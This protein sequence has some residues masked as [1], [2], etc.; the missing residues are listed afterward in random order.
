MHDLLVIGQPGRLRLL[1]TPFLIFYSC[2]FTTLNAK[3]ELCLSVQGLL[4]FTFAGSTI[5]FE[6]SDI[7]PPPSPTA[8]DSQGLLPFCPVDRCR[9]AAL[10][11][12][13]YKSFGVTTNKPGGRRNLDLVHDKGKQEGSESDGCFPTFTGSESVLYFLL[14]LVADGISC[15]EQ[16]YNRALPHLFTTWLLRSHSFLSRRSLWFI[17]CR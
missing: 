16:V 7:A 15:P 14:L 1:S 12:V 10:E 8:C 17:C 11:R 2:M 6:S 5:S 4:Y 13:G 9:P 3:S